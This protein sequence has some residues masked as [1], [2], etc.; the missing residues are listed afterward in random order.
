MLR[1]RL[2]RVPKWLVVL[3]LLLAWFNWG[4]EDLRKG[5]VPDIGAHPLLA[6]SPPW[7]PLRAYVSRSG[8]E[9]VYFEDSRLLLGESA[10]LEYLA[11]KRQG[12]FATD[13][14]DVAAGVRPGSAPRVPYRDFPFEYPPL[15]LVVMALPRIFASSLAGYRVAFGVLAALLTLGAAWIGVILSG[16]LGAERPKDP[17]RRMALLVLALGPVLVS[18]FDALPALL[19]ALAVLFL[20]RHRTFA[21]GLVA[22]AAVMAK[23]YPVMLLLPWVAILLGER[24]VRAALMLA[25]G[26][27][28][29]IA[30]I[31]SPFL[32]LCPEAFLRSTFVYGARPFQVEGLVGAATVLALG[33]SAIV[34]SFGSYNVISP[35]WLGRGWNVLLPL[36]IAT[37]S[38]LAARQARRDPAASATQRTTRL[39]AWTT[40][41]LALVLVTSKVL[42]PQYLIWLVPLGVATPGA[43]IHRWAI[44]A[45]ALTQVFYPILYDLFVEQGSPVVALIVVCRNAVLVGLA[46]AMLRAAARP[47]AERMPA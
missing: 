37:C 38:V 13:L 31:A 32:W 29:A 43:K 44:A 17:W 39:L 28:V 16:E 20:V 24:R 42:S 41:A 14:R 2:R 36:A 21:A 3:C 11:R 5:H 6:V 22:G 25:S 34:G 9:E 35:A 10:D 8:D 45:A 27:G 7:W 4:I 46:V 15:P 1:E 12:D 30:A 19:V 26:A 18:R 47:C 33:K 23:L 40:A